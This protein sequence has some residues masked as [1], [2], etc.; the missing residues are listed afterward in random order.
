[1]KNGRDSER[2]T[3]MREAMERARLDALL[4]RLPENVLLL[5]GYWPLAGFAFA[6][7]PGD[8]E[9]TLIVPGG[10]AIEAQEAWTKSIRTFTFGTLGMGDPLDSVLR[11]LQ[12]VSAKA[13][14]SWKSIGV[15]RSFESISPALNAGECSVPARR[16]RGMLREAFSGKRLRDATGLLERLRSRKTRAEIVKL[17][18]ANEIARMG[19]EAFRETVE[20]GRKACELVGIVESAIVSK[21]TGYKGA[22]RVRAFA[23]ISSGKDTARAWRPCVISS[24][25]RLRKGDIVVLELGCVVDGFWADRTRTRIVGKPT[26]KVKRMAE[27]V[28]SAQRAAL[29]ACRA[30]VRAGE[31]DRAARGTIEERGYGK[32]FIHVTGHG[33]GWRYHEPI[34]LVA[35]GSDEL[36]EEGM[37][38]TVEPGVYVPGFGGMRVED[39]VVERE[40]GPEVLADFDKTVWD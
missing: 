4:V 14:R 12:D 5:T 6:L 9:A 11:H 16:T 7:V 36:L 21:G 34:P 26:E 31:V 19:L 32:Y 13:G 20:E 35:P 29:A 37:V 23:Q 8:G 39:D 33:I 38:H 27:A 25:K 15:E 3:R 30:G 10:E 17:H 1:M 24:D 2:I 18:R 28:L 40:S 22:K